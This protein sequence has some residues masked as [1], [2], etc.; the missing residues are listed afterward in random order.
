MF[1][2]FLGKSS[3]RG[4]DK[5]LY[6]VRR[7]STDGKPTRHRSSKTSSEIVRRSTDGD[8]GSTTSSTRNPFPDTAPASIASTTFIASQNHGEEGYLPSGLPATK[9]QRESRKAGDGHRRTNGRKGEQEKDWED[10][11]DRE[12]IARRSSKGQNRQSKNKSEEKDR[13]LGQALS[14]D[15]GKTTRAPRQASG[16]FN[17]QV[18]SA[19]F[20]QFPG[21]YGGP[22]GFMGG[23]AVPTTRISDHVPDQFPGQFP[24]NSTAPYRP[25]LAK[26]EGGPGLA[27]EYYGD[28]GQSVADQPGVRP[29][30]PAV[31]IG[32]DPHLQAPSAV[33]A[34]P[35]E[36]SALGGVGAA[37]SFFT[38]G[39]SG[40]AEGHGTYSHES[41]GNVNA[42]VYQQASG[43]PSQGT[44]NLTSSR[45]G[46]DH[47]SSSAPAIPALGAA[48][49]GAAAGY[50][51]SSQSSSHHQRPDYVTSSGVTGEGRISTHNNSQSQSQNYPD[52]TPYSS[53]PTKPPKHSSYPSIPVAA[54]AGAVGLAATSGHQSSHQWSQH[55]P[56]GQQQVIAVVQEHRHHGPLTKLA[57]FFRDPDGVGRFE[58][59]TEAIGVCKSCFEPGSSPR[60]APRKHY[61]H[62]LRPQ[63]R[64]GSK[65]RISKDRRYSSSSNESL[66]RS[67]KSWIEKG[68][69]GFTLAKVGESLFN[70]H[71]GSDSSDRSKSGH[72]HTLSGSRRHNNGSSLNR[73]GRSSPGVARPS[74]EVL[75]IRHRHSNDGFTLRTSGTGTSSSHHD[76]RSGRTHRSSRTSYHSRHRSKS[77]SKSRSSSSHSRTKLRQSRIVEAAAGAVIGSSIIAASSRH[78]SRSPKHKQGDSHS[79]VA[80]SKLEGPTSD[81]RS[82]RRTGGGRHSPS[83]RRRSGPVTRSKSTYSSSF[84]DSDPGRPKISPRRSNRRQGRTPQNHNAEAISLGATTE[85]LVLQGRH[86][87]DNSQ[88]KHGHSPD[89]QSALSNPV[90]HL[91]EQQNW[92]KPASSEDSDEGLWVDASEDDSIH[93]AYGKSQESL[94]S[95]SS[96]LGK[97]GWRWGW[98]K[99]RKHNERTKTRQHI[100]RKSLSTGVIPT[101]VAETPTKQS[102]TVDHQSHTQETNMISGPLSYVHPMPTE[103]PSL[104]DVEGQSSALSLNQRNNFFPPVE[105]PQPISPVPAAVYNSHPSHNYSSNPPYNAPIISPNFY[106]TQTLPPTQ[107]SQNQVAFPEAKTLGSFPLLGPPG[108]AG[109]D[110]ATPI[111]LRIGVV[112]VIH[113]TELGSVVLPSKQRILPLDDPTVRFAL[114]E[115]Q[116]K[117]DKRDRRLQETEEGQIRVKS[118]REEN[119]R[120]RDVAQR[121]EEN[122]KR[123]AVRQQ[124][125]LDKKHRARR[126]EQEEEAKS[127]ARSLQEDED[128]KR[129][130]RSR[131][132]QEDEKRREKC[133]QRQEEDDRLDRLEEERR[134]KSVKEPA[135]SKGASNKFGTDA[136]E[137]SSELEKDKTAEPI[138][139]EIVPKPRQIE[140]QIE[141]SPVGSISTGTITAAVGMVTEAP[142]SSYSSPVR[143]QKIA[144]S[145]ALP[146]ELADIGRK[147]SATEEQPISV[148]KAVA[149]KRS[150]SHEDY[151]DFFTPTELLSKSNDHRKD[152]DPN[153]DYNLIET[154]TIEPKISHDTSRSP[155]YALTPTE[156]EPSIRLPWVPQLR[157]ITPTPAISRA[158]TPTSDQSGPTSSPMP[159]N[160]Q[161]VATKPDSKK[162]A[163][164][165]PN[166]KVTWGEE[167]ILVYTEITPLDDSRDQFIAS[168]PNE[169]LVEADTK[170]RKKSSPMSES[171]GKDNSPYHDDLEFAALLAAGLEAT[172]FDSSVVTDNPTFRQRTSPPGS[173][174]ADTYSSSSHAVPATMPGA[175][176]EDEA[177]NTDTQDEST[178]GDRGAG[179]KNSVDK[180]AKKDK[181]PNIVETSSARLSSKPSMSKPTDSDRGLDC[182]SSEFQEIKGNRKPNSKVDPGEDDLV[183]LSRE[184]TQ[185][186]EFD[187]AAGSS[188]RPKH[189][190]ADTESAIS[191]PLPRRRRKSEVYTTKQSLSGS[192]LYESPAEDA[193]SVAATAPVSTEKDESKRSR[194]KS[195][196]K[197]S[198]AI[199]AVDPDSNAKG[200][201]DKKEGLISAIFGRSAK[202]SNELPGMKEV[203]STEIADEFSE[204]N[205]NR[206]S[207]ERTSSRAGS[208]RGEGVTRGRSDVSSK[209]RN[210]E[211]EDY[212][213]RSHKSRGRKEKR[214]ST[215]EKTTKDSGRITQDLPA[216]VY[217]PAFIGR[218]YGPQQNADQREGPGY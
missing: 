92:K 112:P 67:K 193:V 207:E 61:Y 133:R 110:A 55:S 204:S 132:E 145:K 205:R 190:R 95:D 3:D 52:S 28:N 147:E 29:H 42:P 122:G 124:D 123:R 106:Q 85:T 32:A 140:S 65:T 83:R 173:E 62:R 59:Y 81:Y 64:Y 111:E 118:Q 155:A 89:K 6:L 172:G 218:T 198:T 116:K 76:G 50:F 115:E 167:E 202:T 36:P 46:K 201:K 97:W 151:V 73:N 194:K 14:D 213:T 157:L 25:P 96:A 163:N 162:S 160:Q 40:G 209:S 18:G 142:N 54:M 128:V 178:Q 191:E 88:Q 103:D 196:R 189:H 13:G 153:A 31:I 203:G 48:A 1:S 184:D 19:E 99:N 34:P 141:A 148:W 181:D 26:S 79:V 217:T 41:M 188:Y 186:D 139:V 126:Q 68:I 51:I 200:K 197:S 166:P 108:N 7:K 84:S 156:D 174:R 131:R 47:H 49:V 2:R 98:G 180:I 150:S 102:P 75:P 168:P 15:V 74:T 109:I 185:E 182:E 12:S 138:F 44:Q 164:T 71:S 176:G 37:A 33:A 149:K 154:I 161:A 10:E 125:E 175:F 17:A 56:S 93:L 78:R 77:R 130:E 86:D 137:G 114:T 165:T 187:D 24:I 58:E 199:D 120:S 152:T 39:F 143:E 104:F 121:K 216:K 23:P 192:D 101:F 72:I 159:N 119:E 135:A 105:H 4:E 11:Q 183:L 146:K 169:R 113:E 136:S 208:Q 21:Q 8:R 100:D 16:S 57:D 179:R 70:Q 214:R 177:E 30:R 27:A 9:S 107:R 82:Q 117:K 195:K 43:K 38:D 170:E 91:N 69:A 144:S 210:P 5:K 158:P 206:K 215:S 90:I 211:D 87:N 63:E 45:P 80:T 127:L 35:P 60:D 129:R 66:H 94:S 171:I 22:S 53:R 212:E 20:I 134:K